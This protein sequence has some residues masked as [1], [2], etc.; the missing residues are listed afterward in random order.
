MKNYSTFCNIAIRYI[1]GEL[2]HFNVSKFNCLPKNI[3]ID[4]G[5]F[6]SS[7]QNPIKT[8]NKW[9]VNIV[10]GWS[11]NKLKCTQ[12][13]ISL[14][15]GDKYYCTSNPLTSNIKELYCNGCHLY[16]TEPLRPLLANDHILWKTKMCTN[17][18][19][20]ERF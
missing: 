7:L 12:C 3:R 4:I 20:N 17:S 10:Q 5:T 2:Q 8:N 11:D 16:L 15:N 18:S 14:N 19:S 1:D 6:I 13:N 9:R